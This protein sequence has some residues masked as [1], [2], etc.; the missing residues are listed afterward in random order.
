MPGAGGHWKSE[1]PTSL[2]TIL[3]WE[4]RG[5]TEGRLGCSYPLLLAFTRTA[6]YTMKARSCTGIGF[7]TPQMW[8]IGH[9]KIWDNKYYGYK[10]A[11]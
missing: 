8:V 9:D 10:M 11:T 3:A 1:M 4:F 5:R 2:K 6:Y 7:I